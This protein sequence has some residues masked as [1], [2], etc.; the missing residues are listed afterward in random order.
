MTVRDNDGNIKPVFK[1]NWLGRLLGLD[2]GK[3]VN[4]LE[5][6]NQVTNV[7]FAVIAGLAGDINAQDA[8]GYLALGIGTTSA[9]AGDTALESEIVSGGIERVAVTPTQITIAVTSD[10]L[11]FNHTFVFTAPFNV[12]EAGIFNNTPGGVML[13]HVVRTPYPFIATDNLE[14]TW[15]FRIA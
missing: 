15:Q 7:S 13:S 9:T 4:H 5:F 1:R 11:Q 2:F 8:F 6:S 3:F 14:I 10:T 12:S